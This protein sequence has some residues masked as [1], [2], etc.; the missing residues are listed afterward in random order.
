MSL[1]VEP[2]F[3]L[4]HIHCWEFLLLERSPGFRPK[5]GYVGMCWAVT[6]RP[7]RPVS[8]PKEEP[9][10]SDREVSGLLDRG[11]THLK[12]TGLKAT[13]PPCMAGSR[14]QAG[15]DSNLHY[16]RNEE[17]TICRRN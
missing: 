15:H 8:R 5:R 13:P 11:L 6:H 3:F 2:M 9:R 7:A 17:A 10:N 16:S 4:H 12:Q 1:I 14:Q